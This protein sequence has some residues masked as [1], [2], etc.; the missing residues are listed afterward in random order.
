MPRRKKPFTVNLTP[1][2]ADKLNEMAQQ[3]SM[4][5]GQVVSLLILKADL[6]LM[7]AW[8]DAEVNHAQPA[9][10]TP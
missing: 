10:K 5:R 9:T 3:M 8:P 2:A 1:E 4:D 7:L 6:R